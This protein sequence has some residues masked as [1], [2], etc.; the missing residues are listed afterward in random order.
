MEAKS[1][2]IDNLIDDV[3]YII[4][5]NLPIKGKLSLSTTSKTIESRCKPFMQWTCR[6]RLTRWTSK[7]HPRLSL[8]VDN[9]IRTSKSKLVKLSKRIKAQKALLAFMGGSQQ[10]ATIK[11]HQRETSYQLMKLT[12]VMPMVEFT[13]PDSN[14]YWIHRYCIDHKAFRHVAK[15]FNKCYLCNPPRSSYSGATKRHY[16]PSQHIDIE[17]KYKVLLTKL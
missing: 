16:N 9:H 7:R 15:G 8:I 4:W 3:L 1:C 12:K 13:H 2:R 14:E 11:S 6:S 10:I 5:D 17:T